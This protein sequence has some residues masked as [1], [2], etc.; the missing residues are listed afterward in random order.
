MV[1]R[2]CQNAAHND[3][4]HVNFYCA[5]WST[6]PGTVNLSINRSG[7]ANDSINMIYVVQNGTCNLDV[8]SGGQAG[9][10]GSAVSVLTTCSGCLTPTKQN[11]F[12][13]ANGGQAFCTATSLNTPSSPSGIFDSVFYTGNTIDGP[14]QTDEN[15]FWMHAYNGNSL[16]PISVAFGESC[17]NAQQN[18]AGRVAAYQSN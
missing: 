13:M 14:T 3:L 6:P 9:F 5:Q 4:H 2:A 1:K 8:D 10:Q 17:G 7:S 15:N 12:I 16:S 18:W 11:D